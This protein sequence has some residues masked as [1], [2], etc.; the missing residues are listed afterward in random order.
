VP[1]DARRY[2]ET[3]L[4]PLRGVTALPDDP[5]L[6]YGV[7]PG[8]D[9]AALHEQLRR[10]RALWNQRSGAGTNLAKV[11]RLLDSKDQERKQKVGDQLLDPAWWQGEARRRAE[12]SAAEVT[13]LAADLKAE[14]GGSGTVTQGQLDGI[15]KHSGLDD[16][17]VA[18]AARRAG[19]RVVEAVAIPDSSG[20]EPSAYQVLR[21]KLAEAGAPTVVHLLHPELRGTFKVIGGFSV[22]SDPR[23]RLDKEALRARSNQAE[24]AADRSGTRAAKAA[25]ALLRTAHDQGQDLCSVTVF[26]LADLVRAKRSERVPD[27]FIESHLTELGLDA[28]DAVLLVASTP[29]SGGASAPLKE[30]EFVRQLLAD[31]QL[32]EAQRVLAAL[33]ATAADAAEVRQAVDAVDAELGRLLASFRAAVAA[34]EV[35]RAGGLLQRARE[36][37]ADDEAVAREWDRLPPAPPGELAA[38]PADAEVRLAWRSAGPDTWYRVCRGRG[39]APIDP[40]DGQRVTETTGSVAVDPSP[41]P[42][43]P[44]A[45]SVFASRNRKDWSRPATVSVVLVPAVSGVEVVAQPDRVS[46]TWAT[47][48]AAVR[49]EVR[50]FTGGRGA[51][52]VGGT[53]VTAELSRFDDTGVTEG[54]EYD[55]ALTAVY[56]GSD[57]REVTAKPVVVRARPRGRA[58]PVETLSVAAAGGADGER[59]TVTWTIRDPSA[60]VRIRRYEQRPSHREGEEIPLSSLE[61]TGTEVTGVRRGSRNGGSLEARVPPGQFVYVAFSIG[62]GGALV[63]PSELVSHT[64]SVSGL[65]VRRLDRAA[66]LSWSWPQGTSAAR[67]RWSAPG[68]PGEERTVTRTQYTEENGC[69]LPLGPTDL[70]VEVRAVTLT[71]LG[72]MTSEPA[73]VTIPGAPVRLTYRITRRGWSRSRRTVSVHADRSCGPVDL[74]VVAAA[75]AIM[76]LRPGQ[77]TELLRLTG[78]ALTPEHPHVT[79]IEVP[80]TIRRPFWLRCFLTSTAGAS[81]ADPPVTEMWV[82]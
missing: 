75:G 74:V 52:G 51:V 34:G 1:F 17:A 33:P 29:H 3:V 58:A 61:A 30:T 5:L 28:G 23:A 13:K 79:E 67:V 69:R 40:E 15:A 81:I 64:E 49:V 48:P 63:G 68:A 19:L 32:R 10:V 45:Y 16:A 41:Y 24:A 35:D 22:V 2:E 8:M 18:D 82:S 47:N 59:V 36:L 71:P 70:T 11:C 44:T 73:T 38:R 42:G 27:R 6:L 60:E 43:E 72:T 20:L 53:P 80:G 37:A 9:R 31:G 7:E 25:L 56:A 26:H 62:A 12:R 39:R 46:A 66:V 78:L 14:F 50:R 57:G 21:D 76:P 55:Y 4:K 54:V 65:H 77:G